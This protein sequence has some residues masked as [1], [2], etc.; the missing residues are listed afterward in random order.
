MNLDTKGLRH[1]AVEDVPCAEHPTVQQLFQLCDTFVAFQCLQRALIEYLKDVYRL[2]KTEEAYTAWLDALNPLFDTMFFF[3]YLDSPC[4][5]E[6]FRDLVGRVNQRSRAFYFIFLNRKYP[7]KVVMRG[8]SRDRTS[9]GFGGFK[10]ISC[11]FDPTQKTP[12]DVYRHMTTLRP[13]FRYECSFDRN[14]LTRPLEHCAMH[15]ITCSHCGQLVIT[16]A[17]YAKQRLLNTSQHTYQLA[18]QPGHTR[19]IMWFPC[20]QCKEGIVI[21]KR[22]TC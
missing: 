5:H 6:A 22:G 14:K 13:L 11:E 16:Q 10:P 21:C 4:I 1:V 18:H 12:P 19:Y 17:L 9:T 8:E 2:Y 3:G 20:L 7:G 15:T